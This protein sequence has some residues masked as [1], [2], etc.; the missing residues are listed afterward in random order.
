MIGTIVDYGAGWLKVLSGEKLFQLSTDTTNI[1]MGQ[2]YE[3]NPLDM[4][5]GCPEQPQKCLYTHHIRKGV[6]K[7]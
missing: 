2:D 7:Q 1:R 4:T 3:F 5:E 6:K